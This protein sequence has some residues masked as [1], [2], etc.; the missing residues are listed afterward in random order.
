V[1]T[2]GIEPVPENPRVAIAI[3]SV[4]GAAMPISAEWIAI[5]ARCYTGPALPWTR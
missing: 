2:V 1:G 5:F 3:F 4:H